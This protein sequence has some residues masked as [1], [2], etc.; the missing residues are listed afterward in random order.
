MMLS[1]TGKPND[2]NIGA[3]IWITGEDSPESDIEMNKKKRNNEGLVALT[4]TRVAI[5]YE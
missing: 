4:K 1:L 2:Q 5:N 3:W